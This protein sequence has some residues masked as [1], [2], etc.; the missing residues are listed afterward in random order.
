MTIKIS[1]PLLMLIGGGA[2]WLLGCSACSR[3]E[4]QT[5]EPFGIEPLSMFNKI[6]DQEIDG[7]V[8]PFRQDYYL[9]AGYK[10]SQDHDNAIDSFVCANLPADIENYYSYYISI[11]QK[12]EITNVENL[13][14]NPRA[15]DSYSIDH[16][17]IFSYKWGNGR[18]LGAQKRKG[19]SVLLEQRN[20]S[21][22]E[23]SH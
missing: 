14:E 13:Q 6:I 8:Y 19:K 5:N 23:A 22:C 10:G 1:F 7:K 4:K 3:P 9:V 17:G 15:F 2:L 16:D 20:E 12:S 18:F 11:Y 21:P